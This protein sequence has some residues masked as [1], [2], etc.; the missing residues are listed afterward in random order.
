MT[1]HSQREYKR[2]ALQQ[3]TVEK[4]AHQQP[5]ISPS[6]YNNSTAVRQKKKRKSRDMWI[7]LTFCLSRIERSTVEPK[8]IVVISCCLREG[9][10]EKSSLTAFVCDAPFLSPEI[11]MA[12]VWV[13]LRAFAR[14]RGIGWRPGAVGVEKTYFSSI[15]LQ[16]PMMITMLT[17]QAY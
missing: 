2:T 12:A 11:A 17:T 16:I 4:S 6:V 14:S 15:K 5:T 9:N 8:E 10:F 7:Q 3:R 1:H 13:G